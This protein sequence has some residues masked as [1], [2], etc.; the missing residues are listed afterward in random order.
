M[1]H[2][3]MAWRQR[4]AEMQLE[5]VTARMDTADALRTARV[6]RLLALGGWIVAVVALLG[7]VA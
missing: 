4:A 1:D 2:N 7:G 3:H 5:A 6:Y